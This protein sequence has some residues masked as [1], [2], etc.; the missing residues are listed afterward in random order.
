MLI[1]GRLFFLSD[2]E[3]T[4]NIYSCALDGTGVARHTDHDGPYAR[5]PSTDGHRIVYH[6]AGDIWRLDGPDAPAPRRLDIPLGS[7]SPPR[8]PRL[9]TARHHPRSLASDQTGQA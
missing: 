5:N 1:G 7:P 4:G 2:H 6:V 3:G 9:A 8:A